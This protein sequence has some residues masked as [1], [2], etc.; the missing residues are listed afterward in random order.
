LAAT[1]SVWRKPRVARNPLHGL[2]RNLEGQ[3]KKD[4]IKRRMDLKCAFRRRYPN[5]EKR[6]VLDIMRE[7]PCLVE[8]EVKIY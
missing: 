3:R 6:H 8:E 2:K 7:Y 4:G 1:S 5:E